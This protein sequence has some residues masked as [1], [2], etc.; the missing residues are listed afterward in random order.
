MGKEKKPTVEERLTAVESRLARVGDLLDQFAK[1]YPN[2][3]A[4]YFAEF[5][6]SDVPTEGGTGDDESEDDEEEGDSDD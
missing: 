2:I 5:L 1:D 3:H 6:A 4:G